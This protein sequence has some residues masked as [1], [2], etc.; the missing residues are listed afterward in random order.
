MSKYDFVK[1]FLLYISLFRACVYVY[2]VEKNGNE[3][4]SFFP[5]SVFIFLNVFKL[6]RSN[7]QLSPISFT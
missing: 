1:V 2:T 6:N 4:K 3:G 5:F 7:I